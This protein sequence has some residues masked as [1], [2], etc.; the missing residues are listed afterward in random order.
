MPCWKYAYLAFL[1]NGTLAQQTWVTEN[2]PSNLINADRTTYLTS[3]QMAETDAVTRAERRE[4][5][6]Q[7]RRFEYI[8]ANLSAQ[9]TA[10]FHDAYAAHYDDEGPQMPSG[11]PALAGGNNGP[12]EPAGGGNKTTKTSSSDDKP[13]DAKKSQKLTVN[14]N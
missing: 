9:E 1:R 2:L 5:V 14:A 8:R 4:I 13:R 10:N 6:E 7:S 11:K 12:L 3:S